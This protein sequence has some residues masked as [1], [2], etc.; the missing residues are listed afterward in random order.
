MRKLVMPILAALLT[1]APFVTPSADAAVLWW[2]KVISR[3][4]TQAGCMRAAAQGARGSLSN[5]RMGSDE[6]TGTSI[7]GKVYVAVT[8]VE[9]GADQRAIAIIAGVGDD[10]NWVNQVMQNTAEAVRTSGVPD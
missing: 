4:R 1:I 5:V 8:C 2:K 6:V 10:S 9:R 7:D 3:S